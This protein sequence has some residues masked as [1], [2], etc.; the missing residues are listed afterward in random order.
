MN[1]AYLEENLSA[2]D[3]TSPP[4]RSGARASLCSG[5]C[6]RRENRA[7]DGDSASQDRCERRWHLLLTGARLRINGWTTG[8]CLEG[9]RLHRLRPPRVRAAQCGPSHASAR[10][11]DR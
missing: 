9:G 3:A 2:R 8:A 5:Y 10:K 7:V 6:N 1:F 4:T 11:R